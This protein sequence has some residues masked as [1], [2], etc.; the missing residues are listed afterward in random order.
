MTVLDDLFAY[1]GFDD[2]DCARLRDV[3]PILAPHFSAIADRFYAA[4]AA[5][6]AASVMSGADQVARLHV[7]LVDWMSSGLL[8]PYDER[9]YDKRSRIGRRHVAI[10]LPHDYMFTAMSV[11]RTAYLDR[12]EALCPPAD[13]W[14]IARSINKLLDVELA[15]MV[16]HYHLDARE[17]LVLR[18]QRSQAE[19]ITA[20]RTMSAGLAHEVRNPLHAAKLQLELLE[21][22]LRKQGV[23]PTLVGPSLLAQQ[24]IERLTSL[25]NDFLA[26]A[27]PTELDSQSHDIAR[28]V[29]NVVE[30][31][32][33][34]AERRGASLALVAPASLFAR[35]DLAK[36]HQVTL[37]LVRNAIEA[38]SPGGRVSV[39]LTGR[40]DCFD[41]RV[42]D[43]GEGIPEELRARIY[44][45]FFSTKETGTGLGLSIVHSLVTLHAGEITL[46]SGA[47]GTSFHVTIPRGL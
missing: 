18:E 36:L 5:S 38:V 11:V 47:G 30:L 41:L 46:A 1:V 26:F 7:T 28:I 31:E 22:R 20:M 25:L 35:V 39:E 3:H 23:D 12:I 24:E 29:R 6:P 44:E 9:F 19:R 2:A 43:D 34:T 42:Q 21:R 14:T 33:V 17:K 37:N 32:R 45:P 13:A 15:I 8:G 27:R 4:V 10:G 16:R 40:D